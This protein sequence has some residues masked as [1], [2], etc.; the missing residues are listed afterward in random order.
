MPRAEV[1][2]VITLAGIPAEDARIAGAPIADI[3]ERGGARVVL[4]VAGHRIRAGLVPAP[5]RVVAVL[6]IGGR[7]IREGGVA[8]GEH[9]AGNA[10]E[11]RRGRLVVDSV[12]ARDVARSHQGDD[13]TRGGHP[14]GSGPR[15]P[16]VV[17]HGD[18]YGIDAR[19]AVDVR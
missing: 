15:G 7:A 19:R 2:A 4:V 16:A 14:G 9:G 5:A 18:P 11:Q 13:L 1:V 10:V 17:R 3:A 6:V 8:Q 12:A